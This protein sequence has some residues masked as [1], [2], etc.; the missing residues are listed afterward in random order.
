[1]PRLVA[2]LEL[3]AIVPWVDY[4]ELR[5]RLDM[6]E[7]LA[8]MA[9]QAN[10]RRGEYLRGRCPLCGAAG[11]PRD[12]SFVVHIGRKLFKCF[13]CDQGGDVINLW[14]AYRKTNLNA[15]AIELRNLLRAQP[16]PK[17]GNQES[18]PQRPRI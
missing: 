7:V 4:R 3:G 6:E 11:S 18:Q 10:N 2:H 15:A 17:S 1:M 8:W 9:W 5:R 12:R 16:N 14:S 13:H